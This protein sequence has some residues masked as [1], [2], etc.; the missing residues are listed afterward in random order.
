MEELKIVLLLFGYILI[1][2]IYFTPTLIAVK[3]SYNNKFFIF[4]CNLLFSWTIIGWL[5]SIVW[6]FNYKLKNK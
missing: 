2:F 4:I 6:V 5:L 3:N 1:Y